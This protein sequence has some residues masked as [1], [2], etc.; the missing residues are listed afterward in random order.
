MKKLIIALCLIALVPLAS[1]AQD[2]TVTK[3]K[4]GYF[5]YDKVLKSMSGYIIVRHNISQL[6]NQYQAEAKRSEDDFNAKYEAFIDEQADL[7]DNIRKKRQAELMDLMDKN[8]AFKA[9]AE[10]LIANAERSATDSL[11]TLIDAAAREVGAER[12]YS[13]IL[14][15]DKHA[16]PFVNPQYCTD[17][18]AAIEE[19]L[20]K[21]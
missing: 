1:V 20:S 12:G 15:T 10:K 18:T 11:C 19:K 21:K 7:A 9:E 16:L 3:P 4:F 2:S 14:N 6:R 5:S 8:T 13:F 17:V